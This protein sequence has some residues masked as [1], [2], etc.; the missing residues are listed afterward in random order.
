V[1]IHVTSVNDGGGAVGNGVSYAWQVSSDHGQTWTVVGTNSSYTPVL[2]DD[3]KLLQLVVTYVDSGE[4]ESVTDSLGTVAP[5]KVWN[6]GSHDWQT[7]N[8]WTSS[9]A[10]TSSDDAVISTSGTY[11]VGISQD[12]VAHSLIITNAGATVEVLSG[13]TLTLAGDLT[14]SAG[15]F[16][17]DSG[18]T[19][20]DIAAVATITGTVIDNGTVEASGGTL[21]IASTGISGT[22]TFQIDAGATLQLDHADALNVTF[23]ASTG[24]LILLDPAHFTGKIAGITGSDVLDLHGFAAATTTAKT[25]AGSYNAVTNITTLTVTDSASHLTETFKLTGNLSSSTWTVTDDHNGGVNIVDPPGAAANV[26][27]VIAYDPGPKVGPVIVNDPGPVGG[28]AANQGLAGFAAGDTFV[29]NFAGTG[30]TTATEFDPVTDALHFK[31]SISLGALAAL[32]ETHDAGHG[33]TILAV[34]VND[35]ITQAG[36]LKAQLHSSDFHFV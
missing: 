1:A 7:A 33:N 12:A 17:I 29:F 32:D 23:A 34:D 27:P 10:P 30:H 22:G 6:G 13:H 31:G 35:W 8:Q 2:T 21:E 15:A 3:G 25:G 18:A 20:K 11:T 36:V 9:G 16:K 28:H 24:K 4:R 26:G 5:A 14:V 19:L